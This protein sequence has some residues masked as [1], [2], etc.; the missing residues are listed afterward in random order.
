MEQVRSP[1][2]Q[3]Q[4]QGVPRRQDP[5]IVQ[6]RQ[7]LS[8]QQGEGYELLP[9]PD[10]HA[11]Y[12][13]RYVLPQLP[14]LRADPQGHRTGIIRTE[15][16]GA[17]LRQADRP[18]LRLPAEKADG[19]VA[20]KRRHEL[21]VGIAVHVRGRSHLLDL[22][23][24]HQH[25]LVGDAHG[26]LLV[27]GDKDGRDP[28]FP[29]DAPD[30]LPQLQPQPGVQVAQRL[31][32]QQNLGL[33]HQRP[34]N[35][36]PLLLAAGELSGPALEIVL[37]LHEAGGLL[38]PLPGLLLFHLRVQ[39]REHDVL[40]H[41]HVRVQGIVLKDQ[42]DAPLLRRQLRHVLAVKVDSA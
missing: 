42:A 2:A 14:G 24:L 16:Q 31:V 21:V 22:P 6:D 4:A 34:G 9:A 39:Q 11:G 17:A 40:L 35:G 26:L 3:C 29:L 15:P 37:D 10:L 33:L 30:L 8:V 7:A 13:R 20:Q 25:D 18:A 1:S 41:R 32:Q 19:R 23:Q 38:R 27:M 5:V 28:H 36:H 12:R